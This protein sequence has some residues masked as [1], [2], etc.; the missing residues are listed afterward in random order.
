VK[1]SF[2]PYV[3]CRKQSLDAPWTSVLL[4]AAPGVRDGFELDMDWRLQ[5]ALDALVGLLRRWPRWRISLYIFK[6][7]ST[8]LGYAPTWARVPRLHDKPKTTSQHPMENSSRL[9]WWFEDIADNI[10][11]GTRSIWKIIKHPFHQVLIDLNR[12]PDGW[13][14]AFL[15]KHYRATNEPNVGLRWACTPRLVLCMLYPSPICCKKAS[16]PS[17]HHHYS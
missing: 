5:L 3:D 6:V 4:Q 7:L 8:Y 11:G 1:L 15:M 10:L 14:M 12:T 2:H 13:A 17:W 16:F 9:L